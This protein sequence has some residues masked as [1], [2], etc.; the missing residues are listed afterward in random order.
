MQRNVSPRLYAAQF[1]APRLISAPYG[2]MQRNE[3]R[4]A[5]QFAS[6]QLGAARFTSLSRSATQRIIP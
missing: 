1:T 6:A 5:S 2:A 3:R 4:A